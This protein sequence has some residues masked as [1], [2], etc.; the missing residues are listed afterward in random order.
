MLM[1]T[2]LLEMAIQRLISLKFA[3]RKMKGMNT[4]ELSLRVARARY[5]NVDMRFKADDG[6]ADALH[7]AWWGVKWPDTPCAAAP[8]RH[9][10]SQGMC[11]NTP[12]A[13]GALPS[14]SDPD[15]R[16]VETR[17]DAALESADAVTLPLQTRENLELEITL[18]SVLDRS[19]YV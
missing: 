16:A 9:R 2:V 19:F 1:E 12:P 15:R 14:S 8:I 18:G 13:P 11:S 10:R 4:K 7:L 6:K 17:I 5:P 3:F